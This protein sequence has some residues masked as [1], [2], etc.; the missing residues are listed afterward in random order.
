MQR[1]LL[2][3]CRPLED[4][5]SNSNS[6]TFLCVPQ[7]NS[8]VPWPGAIASMIFFLHSLSGALSQSAKTLTQH[9]T[10]PHPEIYSIL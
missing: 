1:A 9:T 8:G 4:M 5:S 10:N 3:L 2:V 6:Q 7:L